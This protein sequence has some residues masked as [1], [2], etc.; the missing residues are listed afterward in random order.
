MASGKKKKKGMVDPRLDNLRVALY[1]RT[2]TERGEA[3]TGVHRPDVVAAVERALQVSGGKEA[4]ETITRAWQLFARRVRMQREH[5]LARKSACMHA[6]MRE[7]ER[8]HPLWYAAAA[9]PPPDP[10]AVPAADEA[11]FRTYRGPARLA[12][13]ARSV[14][15]F[16]PREMRVPVDT[17]P[18]DGWRYDW[19]PPAKYKVKE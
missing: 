17:P 9:R 10:R 1:P 16:F 18:R 19:A 7:L 13:E 5:A 11:E 8:A 14:E 15:G 12:V 6:A 2:R 4:H 3:P